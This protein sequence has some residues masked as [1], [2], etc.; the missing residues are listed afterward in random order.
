MSLKRIL[1]LALIAGFT[2]PLAA[3]DDTKTLEPPPPEK[4]I[5]THR[6]YKK[7]L[8]ENNDQVGL[9]SDDVYDVLLTSGGSLWVGNRDGAAIFGDPSSTRRTEVFDQNNGLPNPKVR[10]M[11]ESDGFIYVGTW[12]G[13]IGVYDLA[14]GTWDILDTNDGLVNNLVADL[15]VDDD[16]AIIVATNAG[17]S[18]YNPANGTITNYTKAAGENV[19]G[20]LLD[21]FVSAVE[22]ANTPRGKEYWYMPRWESGIL[23]EERAD[24]GIT[25]ARGEF[26][27]PIRIDTLQ[28][29]LDNTMYE[30]VDG[31]LS[32]G[33]GQFILTGVGNDGLTRRGLIKFDVE[34]VV[35]TDAVVLSARLRVRNVST[36]FSESDMRLQR[37]LKDWGEGTSDAGDDE[38][39]GA[40]ATA[41]DATWK[42]AMFPNSNWAALGGDYHPDASAIIEIRAMGAYNLSWVAM[43]ADVQGWA[44]GKFP[45]YGWTLVNP[46]SIKAL[47]SRSNAIAN[48]NPTLE[49]RHARFTYIT[50]VTSAFPN[51]NVNDVYYDE[52]NDLFYI[53]FST[54]GLAVLDVPAARWTFMT[55]DQGLPSNLVYS[56]VEIDG[57]I[58]VGTQNGLARQKSDGSFQGYDRGGGLP[59][60]RVRRV[61]SDRPDR[62]W[63]GFVESGAAWVRPTTAQ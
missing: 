59:G 44:R 6:H 51:P 4:Q 57:E 15:E 37:T 25:I 54:K 43:A 53:A 18:R 20:D 24:H 30:D 5:T 58:W 28:A 26:N 48:N 46:D 1:G 63:L 12:G 34:T 8:G 39:A 27:A 13:G 61:Y 14:L 16:G 47:G 33:A 22:I 42:H 10:C 23:P 56:I 9:Q 40:P 19:V 60:D 32:N 38:K 45:N 36:G 52:T 21:E 50:E 11:V 3:C 7:A 55:T 29:S 17:V 31:T 2:F 41:G 35:P 62:L 49:V